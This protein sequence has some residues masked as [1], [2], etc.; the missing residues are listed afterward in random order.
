[1]RTEDDIRDK[2][3]NIETFRDGLWSGDEKRPTL[4]AQISALEWVLYSRK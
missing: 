4:N 1:M 2:I 3:R